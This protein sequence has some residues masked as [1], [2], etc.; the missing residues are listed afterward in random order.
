[1]KADGFIA[2][3]AAFAPFIEREY[4]VALKLDEDNPRL[5]AIGSLGNLVAYCLAEAPAQSLAD[6]AA[7]AVVLK[8]QLPPGRTNDVLCD[9]ASEQERLSWSIA[10]DAM[11]LAA[12]QWKADPAIGAADAYWLAHTAY[13]AFEGEDASLES[14]TLWQALEDAA[15]TAY[16]TVPTTMQGVRALVETMISHEAGYRSDLGHAEPCRSIRAGRIARHDA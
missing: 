15:A 6:L 12:A 10:N 8:F 1:M 9:G 11:R 14:V 4:D 3:A 7:K 5:D 2:A 13:N 16:R